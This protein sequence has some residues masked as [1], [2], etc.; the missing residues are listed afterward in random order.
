G[1]FEEGF[2]T[3]SLFN[4]NY[5]HLRLLDFGYLPALGT[6]L[7]WAV[8]VVSIHVAW[9]IAVPIALIESAFPDRRDQAWL[10]TWGRAGY[11][12][13]FLVGTTLIAVF[14]YKQVPFIASPRQLGTVGAL[15]V[16]LCVTVIK[17]PRTG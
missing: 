8:F 6:A 4:P 17:L 1:L 9:S 14:T 10:G 11:A 5:L 7:P 2:I 3:Q 15:I 16:G 12:L 13:A